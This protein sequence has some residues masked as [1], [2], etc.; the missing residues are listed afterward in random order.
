MKNSSLSN[1]LQ[2]LYIGVRS[3]IVILNFIIPEESSTDEH[4]FKPIMSI[5]N[6]TWV[7][8][9]MAF[10]FYVVL[11]TRKN[12]VS[13]KWVPEMADSAEVYNCIKKFPG[14]VYPALTPNESLLRIG[15]KEMATFGTASDA[16][17]FKNRPKALNVSGPFWKFAH[18]DDTKVCGY[19]STVVTCLYEGPIKPLEVRKVVEAFYG[20]ESYEFSLGDTIG[21]GIPGTI[22]KMLDEVVRVVPPKKLPVHFHDKYVIDTSVSGLGGCLYA[23]GASCNVTTEDCAK[24]YYL[25]FTCFTETSKDLLA[26]PNRFILYRQRFA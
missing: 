25:P 13:P 12:I 3:E 26:T 24:T 20:M 8:V 7:N 19:V 4:Q 1:V 22:S 5:K 14:I 11:T 23:R 10:F 2:N 21:I 17:S 9:D 15:A 18:K 16:Q 6:S